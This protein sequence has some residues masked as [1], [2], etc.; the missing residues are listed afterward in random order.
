MKVMR[1]VEWGKP[2]ELR[3]T[4]IPQ[5]S[6]RSVLVKVQASGVCHT[7]VHIIGGSYDLGEGRKLSMA[8]RGISLPITP[9]HEIAG[10]VERLGSDVRTED[11]EIK[12]GVPVVVY[13]WIG[14]GACRKCLTGLENICEARPRTLGI[15]VDGGYAEYVL[16]PDVRYLIPLGDIDP[17]H[18]APLAC[19]GLTALSAVKKSRV[20]SKELIV[21][22]GAGGLG[23]TAIQLVK[24]TTGA[25]V[26]VVDVDDAKLKLAKS[27]GADWGINSGGLANKDVVTQIKEANGG[28]PADAAIDFVGM[29]STASLGF[30]ALG[31]G[32]RMV[33][34][35]LFGGEGKFAL[36]FFPL[37]AVEVLGNFTGTIRDLADMVKLVRQG[38]VKPVVSETY[39]LDDANVVLEK[40]VAGKIVGRAALAP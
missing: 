1:I 37:R 7:D 18:G 35:G 24:K 33:L 21:L 8:D 20:T 27:L 17:M 2:L 26:V 16:V 29:P 3:Q 34:V 11:S 19:S 30:E 28:L 15:F 9:G 14:C 31:R 32:G 4:E 13:P 23:T 10:T 36:P 40:L 6:E 39:P 25:K 5:L 22:L 38:V 12:E